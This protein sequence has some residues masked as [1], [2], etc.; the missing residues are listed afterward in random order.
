MDDFRSKMDDL[1]QQ[2]RTLAQVAKGGDEAKTKEQF[3]K[4]AGACKACHDKYRD[5]E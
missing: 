5:E 4:T 3:R 2:S 1:V